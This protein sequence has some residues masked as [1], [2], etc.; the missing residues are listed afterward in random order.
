MAKKQ[1]EKEREGERRREGEGEK[2][3]EREITYALVSTCLSLTFSSLCQYW[4]CEEE[5]ST[6]QL[7]P[8][9]LLS[10]PPNAL[11]SWLPGRP[12]RNV[13]FNEQCVS[14]F[15]V[16]VKMTSRFQGH[17]WVTQTHSQQRKDLKRRFRVQD[18]DGAPDSG[19]L[20]LWLCR[21][22]RVCTCCSL[23]TE[24]HWTD[25]LHTE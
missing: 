6:S 8:L 25:A 17:T 22:L 7:S 13:T 18:V 20:N 5:H 21:N 4:A 10:S 15:L 11:T 1:G 9:S 19:D 24:P 12:R 23:I 16:F 3:S 2:E 14:G